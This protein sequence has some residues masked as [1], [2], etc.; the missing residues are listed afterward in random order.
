MPLADILDNKPIH[1]P[2]DLMACY[3]GDEV[4][5]T[6]PFQSVF[7]DKVVQVIKADRRTLWPETIL[8]LKTDF[9]R[10]NLIRYGMA[11]FDEQV[12]LNHNQN[13]AGFFDINSLLIYYTPSENVLLYCYWNM[14]KHFIAAQYVYAKYRDYW[15]A[16][17]T[18]CANPVLFIDF[19]CGPLTG[20][21]AFNNVFK[22]VL[23]TTVHFIGIDR[24]E[25]MLEK[26][27]DFSESAAFKKND[28]FTLCHSWTEL[29]TD[30][31]GD[32]FISP[33]TVV[34]NFT[35]A[36]SSL[37]L[38][39][40]HELGGAMQSFMEKYPLNKY[41]LIYQNS[42]G[43]DQNLHRLLE[44]T[45]ALNK[46]LAVN[47]AQVHYKNDKQDWYATNESFSYKIISN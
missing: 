34:F 39:Q 40:I 46:V 30:Q 1:Y 16:E 41:M 13:I 14:R 17:F 23:D 12:Q 19:A 37:D 2:R 8:G 20:A 9:A 43:R 44:K 4:I 47:N 7:E 38:E 11:D 3:D 18:R 35:Y 32:S 26:A 36:L 10:N 27:K 21:L 31:F 42:I 24:S 25:A 29:D 28:S 45:V 15:L 22:D 6:E 5:L 33:N